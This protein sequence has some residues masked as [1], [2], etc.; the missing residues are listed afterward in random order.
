MNANSAPTRIETSSHASFTAR[1]V[2]LGA[3]M[4]VVIGIIDPYWVFYVKTSSLF[5]DYS[6]GGAIFLLF[7]L[8]LMFNVVLRRLW[9][10]LALRPGELVVVTAMMLAGGAVSTMG[11]VG[12]LI[13]NITAPYYFATA[14][15]E[16]ETKLWPFL[17]GWL[18]PL[19][20]GGATTSINK[21][22]SGLKE[23]ESI[24][25]GAWV[26][27]LICWGIFLAALYTCMT[28]IMT[29]MRKQWMD[30]ERLTFPITQ[31]S[32]E[33]CAVAAVPWGPASIL[34]RPLFWFGFAVPFLV[35]SLKALHHYFP[36]VP[37]PTTAHWFFGGAL[38]ICTYLSFAVL[39]FTFLI[40]NRIVFSIWFLNVIS[41]WIR[42]HLKAF[43]LEMTE[44]LP[45]Y[46]AGRSPV[47][48][49]QGV[50]ALLVLV[51]VSLWLSRHHL[52]RV[53]Q[54]AVGIGR[55]DYDRDEPASYRT[56]LIAFVSARRSWSSGCGNRAFRRS[57]AAFS[58]PRR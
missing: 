45:E 14:S 8:L 11:L 35:G 43:R 1:S 33:L 20:A 57:I 47:F 18:S 7:L 10:R 39:G 6:V 4:C 49:H 54:C 19:D 50:G 2:A 52:L 31:I 46:G 41:F 44:E 22:F 51:A 23:G 37:A 40:P 21:F 36:S 26:K 12:S 48:A 38:T 5:F 17:P 29:I 58:S 3:L 34:R 56:A 15:N 25:W 27:P 42:Y 16:W 24:P 53:I 13:P 32:Q 9:G 30:H 28:S 55:A